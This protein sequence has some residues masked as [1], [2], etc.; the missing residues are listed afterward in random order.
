ML[1]Q[2][3]LVRTRTRRRG[4]H[5]PLKYRFGQDRDLGPGAR[6]I[7]GVFAMALEFQEGIG[8]TKGGGVSCKHKQH[9]H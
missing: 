1:G 3:T 2:S 8:L 7:E 5:G 9:T 4:L 6:V